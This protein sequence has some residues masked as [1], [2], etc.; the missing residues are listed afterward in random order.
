MFFNSTAMPKEVLLEKLPG[1]NIVNSSPSYH[2][3]LSFEGFITEIN[4]TAAGLFCA[5]PIELVNHHVLEIISNEDRHHWY[6]FGKAMLKSLESEH[7]LKLTLLRTDNTVFYAQ[8]N[9]LNV[10]TADNS[11]VIQISLTDI[12]SMFC[13]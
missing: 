12:H 5:E 8:L 10:T 11:R 6:V 2:L 13:V 9:C 3:T 1:K 4:P 7:N